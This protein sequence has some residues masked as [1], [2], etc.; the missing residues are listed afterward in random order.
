METYTTTCEIASENLQPRTLSEGKLHRCAGQLLE[1][2][3]I[4]ISC[5]VLKLIL[6]VSSFFSRESVFILLR[7]I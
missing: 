2:M 7:T 1:E 5:P 3:C 4:R 6:L